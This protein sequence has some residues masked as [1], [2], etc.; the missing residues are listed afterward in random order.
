MADALPN[1]FNQTNYDLGRGVF[2]FASDTIMAM[3]TNVAPDPNAHYYSD[4]QST[5]LAAG[6]GYVQG[7]QAAPSVAWVNTIVPATDE[8][9]ASAFATLTCGAV[10]WVAAV[11]FM[12]PY[13]YV[14]YYDFSAPNKNLLV[15]A[16]LGAS[17]TLSGLNGDIENII[18]AAGALLKQN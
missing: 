2:D 4:L 11:G 18:P 7:G 12:G 10:T 8:A 9:P 5:E 6:N 15:W 13:R 14:V 17:L 1:K 3:L 16:D